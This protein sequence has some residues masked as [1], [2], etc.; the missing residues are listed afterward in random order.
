[1]K[2]DLDY[3]F[4]D[5]ETSSLSVETGEIIELAAI[6]T[7]RKGKVLKA[8]GSRIAFNGKID[9]ET[10]KVNHYDP[11]D[12]DGAPLLRHGIEFLRD[13]MV[14]GYEEKYIVVAHFADFDRAFIREACKSINVEDPFIGRAWLDTAQIAWPLVHSGALASRSLDSLARFFGV[15]NERPHTAMGDVETLMRTYW[16]M[17][18]RMSGSVAVGETAIRMAENSEIVKRGLRYLGI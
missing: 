14:T 4:V 3:V 8:W 5:V 9:E 7:N 17:I 15:V 1:V 18:R 12:W 10:K 2:Y 11:L 6:R 16:I 13:A